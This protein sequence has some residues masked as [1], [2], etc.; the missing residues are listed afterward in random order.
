MLQTNLYSTQKS[1]YSDN[2]NH[3]E[4]EQLIGVH[5]MMSL[6]KKPSYRMFWAQNSRDPIIADTISRNRFEKLRSFLHF[7]DNTQCLPYD[8]PNHDK[9]FKMWPFID[10][11]RDNFK[12]IH[13]D[14]FLAVDEIII[15][16]KGRSVMKQHNKAKPH[17]WGIKLFALAS[18]SG[19]IHD[20]EVYVGKG[21]LNSTSGLGLSGDIVVR[22]SEIIPKNENFKLSFDNWYTSYNLMTD[23]KYKGILAIGTVRSNRMAGC[24]FIN[25]KDLKKSGRGT[26]DCKVDTNNGII[27]CK[28]VDTKIVNLF[29]NYVG[30]EP[31]DNVKRWSN[32]QK[33]KVDVQ[34]PNMVKEYNAFM[35]VVDLHNM[36]VELYRINIKCKRYY[37][38]IIF[39]MIDM[40]VVNSWIMYRRDCKELKINKYEPLVVFKYNIAL[41]LL[42]SGKDKIKKRGRPATTS[43]ISPCTKKYKISARPNNDIR[44]DGYHHWPESITDKKKL[45]IKSYTTTMCSK[46]YVSLCYNGNKNCFREYHN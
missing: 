21:T 46:C 12:S 41:A 44:F 35:G 33:K 2:T 10:A 8:D 25:D 11:L 9:L 32:T 22:L 13:V 31:T 26:Y 37:L 19:I 42:R 17:K 30:P 28:W 29:S 24:Q 14:E 38:R 40:C 18:K 36:L 4:V 15:P 5:I 7:N 3:S 23:L 27:A 43:N 20:F 1:G 39:H 45:C 34:R 16:F 6:Y